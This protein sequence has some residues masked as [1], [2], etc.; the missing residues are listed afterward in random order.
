M[1]RK[2]KKVFVFLTVLALL[3]FAAC[4]AQQG[5]N[6]S[7]QESSSA[8][9]VSGDETTDAAEPEDELGPVADAALYRGT[10]TD[11][12]SSTPESSDDSA[13]IFTI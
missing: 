6:P 11:I 5:S 9:S 7:P 2:M 13:V 1:K 12:A 10:I 8:E 3:L 4:N